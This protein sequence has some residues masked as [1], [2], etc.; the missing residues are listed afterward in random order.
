MIYAIDPGTA[1]SGWC[2][3]SQNALFTGK[4]LNEAI[5][6]DLSCLRGN[7]IVLIERFAC[8]GMSIGQE[9][10]DAIEWGG[11]FAQRARDHGAEVLRIYRRDVK[12]TLTGSPRAN[13]AAIRQAILDQYGGKASAVGVKAAPGPLYGVRAD[14][15]SALALVLTYQ[16]QKTESDF[17]A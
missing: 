2:K 10:I 16:R 17:R 7:D 4:A 9:T 13:D 6:L 15:W 3:Q 8:Y 1:Q 11:V 14:A 5:L 12:L